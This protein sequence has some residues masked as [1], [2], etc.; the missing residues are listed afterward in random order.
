M[1]KDYSIEAHWEWLHLLLDLGV[2]RP[3]PMA[4]EWVL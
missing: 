3:S 1:R 4:R 2:K